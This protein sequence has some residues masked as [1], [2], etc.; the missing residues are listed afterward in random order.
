M[1][2]GPL[3]A[4]IQQ[5]A[6]TTSRR[7]GRQPGRQPGRTGNFIC[8]NLIITGSFACIFIALLFRHS[9]KHRA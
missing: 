1:H 3:P 8:A 5:E 9:N 4:H 7:A 6:S 2:N